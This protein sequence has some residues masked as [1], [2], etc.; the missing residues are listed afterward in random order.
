MSVSVRGFVDLLDVS[1]DEK[2][3]KAKARLETKLGGEKF[4]ATYLKALI[5]ALAWS[6][7]RPVTRFRLIVRHARRASSPFVQKTTYAS[8]H[9]V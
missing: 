1:V 8:P 5:V 6:H 7:L 9:A 3:Q 2:L 4:E